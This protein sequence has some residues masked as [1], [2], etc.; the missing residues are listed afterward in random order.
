VEENVELFGSTFSKVEKNVELF[1]STF[2]K[3]EKVEK[4]EKN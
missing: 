3:V 4:V 1:G 2:S